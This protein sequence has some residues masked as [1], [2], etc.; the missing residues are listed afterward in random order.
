VSAAN[1]KRWLLH[2]ESSSAKS[3]DVIAPEPEA[4]L[5]ERLAR[6]TRAGASP[7]TIR[8][9]A[10]ALAKLRAGGRARSRAGVGAD[11]RQAPQS[12]MAG[13]LPDTVPSPA[14]SPAPS[15][16]STQPPAWVLDEE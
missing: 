10:E 14:P 11:P 9:L 15:S 1:R 7:A 12:A 13:P 6:Q 2:R 3:S 4:A 8:T 16:T 5:A